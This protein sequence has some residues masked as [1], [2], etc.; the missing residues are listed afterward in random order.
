MASLLIPLLF[1]ISLWHALEY[2]WVKKDLSY[3]PG[4]VLAGELRPFIKE[5]TL[6][7]YRLDTSTI[8]EVNF[9][10]GRVIP[11]LSKMEDLSEPL[12]R[13]EERWILMPK[14]IFEEVRI[15]RTLP[16]VLFQEFAYK[17]GKLILVSMRP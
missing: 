8:E 14:E 7:G 12:R 11:I 1:V 4:M 9:Y 16:T 17:M 13:G 2:Y 5:S 3:S 6:S 10:T 15:Q